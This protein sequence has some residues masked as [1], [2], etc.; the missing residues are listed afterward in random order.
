MTMAHTDV[1]EETQVVEQSETVKPTKI[2]KVGGVHFLG[3]LHDSNK[4]LDAM[5]QVDGHHIEVITPTPEEGRRSLTNEEMVDAVQAGDFIQ[6][7]PVLDTLPIEPQSEDSDPIDEMFKKHLKI[8]M[9]MSLANKL[10]D[11]QLSVID[12]KEKLG[13]S[14]SGDPLA[15]YNILPESMH[16]I[17]IVLEG[18][19]IEMF[20]I[21]KKHGTEE[22]K[23]THT[24]SQLS[25][26]KRDLIAKL[27]KIYTKRLCSQV[28]RALKVVPDHGMVQEGPAAEP[29]KT[30][31]D[32]W[33]SKTTPLETEQKPATAD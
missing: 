10:A 16:D 7:T 9:T 33:A 30:E 3:A 24:G 17:D 5:R 27:Y 12:G 8:K 2:L 28:A 19:R 6:G 1:M 25:R 20:E 15:V 14:A 18:S 31:G 32:A 4:I 21:V 23:K 13:K 22:E 29:S 26:S 11:L